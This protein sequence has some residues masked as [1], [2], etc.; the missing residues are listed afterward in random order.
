[1][2]FQNV[3]VLGATGNVGVSLIEQISQYDMSDHGHRNPT[4]IV[5]IANSK[6]YIL[7]SSGLVIPQNISSNNIL[8]IISNNTN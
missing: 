3:F 2:S 5:G 6:K 1:M 8:D 7:S 4:R